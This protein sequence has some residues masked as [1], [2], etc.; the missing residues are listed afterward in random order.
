MGRLD[1]RRN[2]DLTAS[3]EVDESPVRRPLR[4]LTKSAAEGTYYIQGPG[5]DYLLDSLSPTDLG[6]EAY[7]RA[8]MTN[9]ATW[10]NQPEVVYDFSNPKGIGEVRGRMT[11]AELAQLT[12]KHPTLPTQF[13][14]TSSSDMN[15][16]HSAPDSALCLT[17]S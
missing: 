11:I 17:Q 8:P 12:A 6:E 7:I 10:S 5:S 9:E 2:V 16:S 1:K 14:G 15:K 13:W 3:A 4:A